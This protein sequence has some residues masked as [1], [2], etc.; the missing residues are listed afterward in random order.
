MWLVLA[1]T[2]QLK[3]EMMSMHS[4]DLSRVAAN[5]PFPLSAGSRCWSLHRPPLSPAPG[6]MGDRQEG[7]QSRAAFPLGPGGA[8]AG[9]DKGHMALCTSAFCPSHTSFSCSCLPGREDWGLPV[10]PSPLCLSAWGA[11][12]F[13]APGTATSGTS[14]YHRYSSFRPG[15]G[16]KTV[17]TL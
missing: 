17:P 12:E 10:S 9:P 16:T 15:W 5:C 4:G 14:T 2:V 7:G 13:E 11:R 1:V 6:S 8:S 3:T